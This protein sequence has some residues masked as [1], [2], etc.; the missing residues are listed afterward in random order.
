MRD[1]KLQ[2]LKKE[3][4]EASAAVDELKS[5]FFSDGQ[6]GMFLRNIL[7]DGDG[8]GLDKVAD[9]LAKRIV[10]VSNQ[11]RTNFNLTDSQKN[12]L[13]KQL[14]LYTEIDAVISRTV[15]AQKAHNAELV[16][17]RRLARGWGLAI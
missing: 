14:D 5:S 8:V 4:D 13:K 15:Q 2:I 9:L 12:K 6:K 11:L 10:E 7:R 1:S 16:N 3:L 17:R